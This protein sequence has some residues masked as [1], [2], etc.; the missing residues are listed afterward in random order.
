MMQ[1]M[2]RIIFCMFTMIAL[3]GCASQKAAVESANKQA[4]CKLSCQQQFKVCNKL[5]HNNCRECSKSS[6]CSTAMNYNKY[7]HEQIVQ[8]GIV[9][10][11]LN[12]YHDPLQCRKTTCNCLADYNVCAQSCTGIIHKRLQVAPVCC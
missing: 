3:S 11:E 6:Q 2:L 1:P 10:R 4:V 9:G 12:S 7:K 5:C 8:G